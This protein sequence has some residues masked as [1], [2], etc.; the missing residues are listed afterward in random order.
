[1]G[2]AYDLILQ[3]SIPNASEIA[4]TVATNY[5]LVASVSNWGGYAISAAAALYDLYLKRSEEQE[6]GLD[7]IEE[8]L[9]QMIPTDAEEVSKCTHMVDAGARDGISGQLALM[10]DG[11]P[12][13]VSL[14]LLQTLR[15][16]ARA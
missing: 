8:Q 16:I 2:K 9:T 3:S 6:I 7:C 15:T 13:Q 11:M 4:C 5:L 10:V 14:D 1:M 12:L